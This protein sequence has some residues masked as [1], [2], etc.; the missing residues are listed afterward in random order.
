MPAVLRS[1]I[2]AL[3]LLLVLAGLSLADET[4]GEA[5]E[6]EP[7]AIPQSIEPAKLLPPAETGEMLKEILAQ[8]EYSVEGKDRKPPVDLLQKISDWFSKLFGN[9]TLGNLDWVGVSLVLTG[10]LLVVY[11]LIR[12]YLGFTRARAARSIVSEVEQLP[13]TSE[14]LLAK[15]KDAAAVGDY[16]AAVRYLFNAAVKNLD[17]PS[18][19]L[20]TNYQVLAFTRRN[21]SSA[22]SPLRKLVMIFEDIWYGSAHCGQSE[23]SESE[24]LYQ[25]FAAALTGGAS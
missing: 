7:T 23:F 25:S 1:L 16:R 15:A 8:P 24:R 5:P 9:H 22:E 2:V 3:A 6:Q 4:N 21:H 19:S 20:Q 10:L 14:A 11:L 17:M 13:A 18:S 12:L